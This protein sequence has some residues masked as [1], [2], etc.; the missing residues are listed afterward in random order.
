MRSFF[1]FVKELRLWTSMST[2]ISFVLQK[3]IVDGRHTTMTA[4]VALGQFTCQSRASVKIWA[5]TSHRET[6]RV[7]FELQAVALRAVSMRLY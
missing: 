7:A 3:E 5:L 1:T 4:R 2:P 6:A